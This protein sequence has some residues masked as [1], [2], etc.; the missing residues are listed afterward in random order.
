MH[1]SWA[2][3]AGLKQGH[4]GMG[5]SQSEKL[6]Y[7][8]SGHRCWGGG[9][10]T[11]RLAAIWKKST[12]APGGLEGRGGKAM[13]RAHWSCTEKPPE[14]TLPK[15]SCLPTMNNALLTQAEVTTG[16]VM[17]GPKLFLKPPPKV[18]SIGLLQIWILYELPR[19]L[20]SHSKKQS[21]PRISVP[22]QLITKNPVSW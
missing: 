12:W 5:W 22:F 3:D 15:W 16:P 11:W 2:L 17:F 6:R 7:Q 18:W 21:A 19:K 9:R 14:H 13:Y 4:G 20:L 8:R 10:S 1:T